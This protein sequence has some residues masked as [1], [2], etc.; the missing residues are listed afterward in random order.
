MAG[1]AF[2]GTRVPAARH[3]GANNGG[4]YHLR[5]GSGPCSA[6][7]WPGLADH[8]SLCLLVRFVIDHNAARMR[9][10]IYCCR[11]GQRELAES[12]CERDGARHR[13]LSRSYRH[14][15]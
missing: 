11:H 6:K 15:G 3:G 7:P 8:A 2:D 5:I 4:L 12:C 1:A 14:G 9:C 13:A 10:R